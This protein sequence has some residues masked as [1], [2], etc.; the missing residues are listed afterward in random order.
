[1]SITVEMLDLGI[2]NLASLRRGLTDAGARELRVVASSNESHGAD[3]M[4]LPG[5]GAFG[6]A[7]DELERR[8]LAETVKHHVARGG[9]LMGV[10]LGMQLLSTASEESPGAAGLDLIHGQV[11]RLNANAGAR[12]PNMGWGGALTVSNSIDFPGLDRAVD[13][14]FVHSYAVVPDDDDDILATSVFGT[15]SFVSGVL[16][17]N[18]L[19]VQFHPEKSSRPGAELLKEVLMWAD[20]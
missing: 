4:V 14:Y 16:H 7:V 3:L 10:C 17:G 2:N 20:G 12:V 18:V 11:R 8:G 19:G 1:M 9:Y 6:A 5:V 15:E 13:Y